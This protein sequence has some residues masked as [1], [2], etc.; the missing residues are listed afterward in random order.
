MV[1]TACQKRS[2]PRATSP[3]AA[4]A[5]SSRRWRAGPKVRSMVGGGAGGENAPWH[6]Q[7]AAIGAFTCTNI[8]LNV[9]NSWALK[10]HHWPDFEFPIFYTMW[11]MVFSAGAALLLLK[12][13]NPAPT[14]LPSFQQFWE[15]KNT[16]VP[17]AACTTLNNG[18]NNMSLT[19]VSLFV[20][21]VI[22]ATAPLPSLFF[23]AVFAGKVYSRPV[24]ASVCVIVVGSVLANA[25]TMASGNSDD[26]SIIGVIICCVS[27][28]ANA[29]KPVLAMISM[30]RA[31]GDV[32]KLAP[33]VVL[34]YDCATSFVFM[35]VYWLLSPEREGSISYLG[36][37]S[38]TLIGIGI[39][40]ASATMA[41]GFNLA[42]YYFVAYTSA[43][44]S[45]VGANG[46][47]IFLISTSA[48][49]AGVTDLLSW[50][51]I[52]L[53]VSAIVL[54]AYI[55]YTEARQSDL[56]KAAAAAT[57]SRNPSEVEVAGKPI[58][59]GEKAPLVPGP[60]RA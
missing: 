47:K 6:K 33:T 3:T 27:L 5:H 11:H 59:G 43:L 40:C 38:T 48:I 45:M 24:I 53:V 46:I 26:N 42:V 44:T 12:Y 32:P 57:L 1:E 55:G 20:N 2:R 30:S 16:I 4:D 28:L 41:F 19:L 15:Y 22:K 58:A 10:R 37:P 35:L 60:S 13:V 9:F 25:H 17:I 21:Q 54:Y 50:I 31:S 14:G 7:A 36:N 8:G 56:A 39:I 51:G 23:S 18:L 52:A 49:A 34:F 29:M